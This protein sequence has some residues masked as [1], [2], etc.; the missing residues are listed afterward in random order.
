MI[1]KEEPTRISTKRKVKHP[2]AVMGIF[3][4]GL[5]ATGVASGA[6]VYG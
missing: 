2:G 6:Y 4:L 1:E 5:E 3:A